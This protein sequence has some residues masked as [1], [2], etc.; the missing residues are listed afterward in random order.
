MISNRNFAGNQLL[1]FLFV[2][3]IFSSCSNRNLLYMSDLEED[4]KFQTEIGQDRQIKIQTGDLMKISLS[5]LQPEMDEMFND[6]S[7]DLDYNKSIINSINV[8]GFLV[9]E[10]GEVNIPVVGRVKLAG[11]TIAEATAL[12]AKGIEEYIV[13]PVVSIKYAN[14][15]ITVIGE[16]KNPSTFYVPSEK[17]NVFEA[18]GLAGDMT[19]YGLRE[20]VRLIR[21]TDGVRSVI[22]LDLND[23]GILAS[24]YYNLKQNDIIYVQP[25]KMKSVK[26]STNERSMVFLALAVS[27]LVPILYSWDA[28]V[29]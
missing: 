22:T 23:K 13:D 26:V 8:Q 27:I 29:N 9:D 28:I 10:N 24:P 11:L 6:P 16:V 20:E 25:D 12:V 7:T 17:L 5:S 15:K 2:T 14:F 4:E 18:L 1:F 3:I 19:E 21:E